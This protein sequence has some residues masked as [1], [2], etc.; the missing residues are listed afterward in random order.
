MTKKDNLY[1]EVVINES[2]FYYDDHGRLRVH[3]LNEAQYI[4]TSDMRID[5]V[6]GK[7]GPSKTIKI[8]NAPKPET[9]PVPAKGADDGG[10]KMRT[11]DM[12]D[13][14]LDGTDDR[15]QK[16]KPPKKEL[17]KF[18][19]PAP[20]SGRNTNVKPQKPSAGKLLSPEMVKKYGTKPTP[21]I[22]LPKRP[23]QMTIGELEDFWKTAK[24]IPKRPGIGRPTGPSKGGVPVPPN[25]DKRMR[26]IASPSSGRV[27]PGTRAVG[28]PRAKAALEESNTFTSLIERLNLQKAEMGE[29]IRDFQKSDAPQFKGKSD[30]KRRIMAIA[31]KLQADRTK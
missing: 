14:D 31:A 1:S 4:S 2:P 23:S 3:V 10:G 12:Q 26:P 15:D 25:R 29:V 17:P 24:K 7:K 28:V 9:K 20:G 18:G 11:A 27:A 30:K 21:G 16:R 22:T 6:T 13:R 5:P 8:S 19:K